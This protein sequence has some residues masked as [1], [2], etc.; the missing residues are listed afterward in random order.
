MPSQAS[1]LTALRKDGHKLRGYGTFFVG[2]AVWEA[3]VDTTPADGA[4]TLTV[5]TVSGAYTA[6]RGG[7][8][9]DVFTSGG[10]YK[11]RTRLRF[12]ATHSATAMRIREHSQGTVKIEAGDTVRVYAEQRLTD[13]LV[14]ANETFAPEHE[15]YSAQN[16]NPGPIACSGGPWAGDSTML[17]IQMTGDTSDWVDPDSNGP[18]THLWTL[19]SGLSFYTGSADTDANPQITGDSG[20]YLVE[21]TVTDADNSV[22]TTQFVPVIIDDDPYDIFIES[23]EMDEQSGVSASVR[24]KDAISVEDVPDGSLFIFWVKETI[25]G[26][27]QSFGAASPGRSHIKLVGYLRRDTSEGDASDD[28]LTF[29]IISPLARLAELV[30]YS[31]VMTNTAS[32]DAWSEI[33]TLGIER[34][35]RLLLLH[36]SNL[37]EAG[38]DL[39]THAS[40]S[41][42]T[43]SQ[44]FLNKS[45]PFGQVSE[46]ADSRDGRF[47]CDRT[48]RFEFQRRLDLL[49]SADR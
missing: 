49:P 4:L 16:S 20:S 37:V 38:F 8:R 1:N 17:P 46:L 3:T 25:N 21:H 40:W 39:I 23:L 33:K 7:F 32:P 10:A 36:Y 27:R 43:Y 34:A 13:K 26:T 19:P 9:V 11:G 28:N 12:N 6:A 47:V 30:G 35:M 45:T 14:A 41:D 5:T 22:S 29:E 48:G 44:L 42:A 31:K 24:F 18:L 15:T 2:A